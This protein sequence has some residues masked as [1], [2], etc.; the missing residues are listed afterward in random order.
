MTLPTTAAESPS[1]ASAES[2]TKENTTSTEHGSSQ[3][4]NVYTPQFHG[5]IN[6]IGVF[7]ET[8]EDGP[9]TG[10]MFE[11]TGNIVIRGGGMQYEDTKSGN[12]EDDVA[13]VEGTKKKVGTIKTSDFARLREICQSLPVPGKYNPL[14]T[15]PSQAKKCTMLL[16]LKLS[17]PQL[18]LNG[19][20][21]DPSKPVRRCTQWTAEA[22]EALTEAGILQS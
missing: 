9:K 22:V 11:V 5:I 21:I 1:M 2:T 14:Q 7:V 4:Y 12:P 15:R 6:H 18:N 3:Y 19:S 8:E 10:R 13:F 20:R 16:I 17:G